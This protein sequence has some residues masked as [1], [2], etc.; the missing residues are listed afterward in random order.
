CR[1]KW[2]GD[3][4]A[5][6]RISADQTRPAEVARNGHAD[7]VRDVDRFSR[8][9]PAVPLRASSL[10]G[11]QLAKISLRGGGTRDLSG[12]SA[13]A[14]RPGRRGA[15]SRHRDNLARVESELDEAP[16]LGENYVSNLVVCFGHGRD[17]L[18]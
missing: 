4:A 12:D 17:H 14:R 1:S 16:P 10:H 15:A 6:C 18:L 7:G 11:K 9:L 2:S 8:L 3:G 13:V 5:G